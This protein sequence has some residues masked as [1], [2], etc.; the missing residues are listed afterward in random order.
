MLFAPCAPQAIW[1]PDLL[2]TVVGRAST[3]DASAQPTLGEVLQQWIDVCR[4]DPE[5]AAHMRQ[6]LLAL[7]P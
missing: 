7:I 1:F 4:T 5:R 2:M 3:R 6:W